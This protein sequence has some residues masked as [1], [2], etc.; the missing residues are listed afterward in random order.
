MVVVLAIPGSGSRVE[1][2][3]TDLEH[4]KVNNR[5]IRGDAGT[6]LTTHATLHISALV[7]HFETSITSGQRYCRVWISSMKW[8]SVQVANKKSAQS[9]DRA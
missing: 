7:P 2:V 4:K 5:Q 8:C 1:Q 9:D 3:I 6:G